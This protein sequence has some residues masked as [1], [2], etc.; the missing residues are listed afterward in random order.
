MANVKI[1]QLTAKGAH[2]ETT[3]RIAIADFNGTTYDSKYITGAQLTPYKKYVAILNQTG[4]NAPTAVILENTLSGTPTLSRDSA[5]NYRITLTGEFTNNKTF[6]LFGSFISTSGDYISTINR[7]D[8]NYI[9]IQTR[10]SAGAGVDD[11]I[12]KMSIEIRVY[13]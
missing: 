6:V 11:V 13:P 3:D 4:T 9:F 8:N 1:S 12:G 10:N 7:A 2:V 5:G